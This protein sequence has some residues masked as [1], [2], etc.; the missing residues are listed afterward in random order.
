VPGIYL[1]HGDRY[2]AMAERP[3]DAEDVLQELIASH[4]EMLA[5]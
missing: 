2:L 5:T 1:K 3:Y 4:P